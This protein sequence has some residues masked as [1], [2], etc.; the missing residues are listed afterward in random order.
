MDGNNEGRKVV[1]LLA[2]S[3]FEGLGFLSSRRTQRI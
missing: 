3:L 2:P 1:S